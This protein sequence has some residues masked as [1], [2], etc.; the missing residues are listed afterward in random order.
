MHLV[1]PVVKEK[2][3]FVF[4]ISD[5]H[6]DRCLQLVE[7]NG[8]QAVFESADSWKERGGAK[9]GKGAKNAPEAVYQV[10]DMSQYQYADLFCHF[11][12]TF[13]GRCLI[14]FWYPEENRLV[15]NS[16]VLMG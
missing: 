13:G 1:K 6:K 5:A 11:S 8:L 12:A 9:E 10:F 16:Q 3:L 7:K 4:H 14:A 15:T 2:P